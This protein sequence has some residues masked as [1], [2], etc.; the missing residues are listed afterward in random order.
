MPARTVEELQDT[1]DGSLSWRRIELA[2]LRAEIDRSSRQGAHSPLTRALARSGVALLYAHWEGFA[3]DAFSAYV[4]FLSR[5]RLKVS[6]LNDGLLRTVFAGL[7]RRVASGDAAA[8]KEM[9]QAIRSPDVVRAPMPRQAVKTKSNL[10]YDVL[11]ELLES[12]GLDPAEFSTRSNLIDRLLCDARNE[13]AHGREYFPAPENFGDLHDPVLVMMEALRHRILEA[14]R[15]ETY[16]T[17]TPE[18]TK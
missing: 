13:I 6:Q 17:T 11:T 1:L 18:Q 8:V 16:K 5:R 9:L 12:V 10:R 15:L 14:V 3:K 4:D 7:Q 2:A